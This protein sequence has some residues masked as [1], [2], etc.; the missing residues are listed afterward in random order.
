MKQRLN[1]VKFV[2]PHVMLYFWLLYLLV[3]NA[4]QWLGVLNSLFVTFKGR[5]DKFG[6]EGS[7]QI[8]PCVI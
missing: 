5:G 7:A 3:Q 2:S 4:D 8:R 1:T 6:Q